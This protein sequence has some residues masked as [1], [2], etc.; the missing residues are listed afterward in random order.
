MSGQQLT[1]SSIDAVQCRGRKFYIKRDDQLSA[2]FA[3][4]KA[5][6]L[7]YLLQYAPKNIDRIVSHGSVQSNFLYSLSVLAK[8]KQWAL[9]FY[10]DHVPSFLQQQPLGNYQAALENGANICP[11]SDMPSSSNNV[12]TLEAITAEDQ[13][14]LF[15]PEGGRHQMAEWGISV[16]AE[17]IVQWAAGQ[18]ITKLT[19]MLPSGTGT[20]AFYL[21][22]HLPFDVLTCA[23]VGDDTYLKQQFLMLSQGQAKLPTILLPKKKYHFGKLYAEFFDMWEELRCETGIEFELLYDPLGWISLFEHI[24]NEMPAESD[25]LYIHQGGVLGNQSM[26]PRYLRRNDKQANIQSNNETTNNTKLK[27]VKG[28]NVAR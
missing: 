16:L 25:V 2:G 22:K 10:V 20:T 24:E 5:R 9:D 14:S 1:G 23:C 6:K 13:R 18:N 19:V 7:A 27:D 17:E 26:L 4:N 21:Q 11:L 8:Q 15:I 3:G 12:A 28:K